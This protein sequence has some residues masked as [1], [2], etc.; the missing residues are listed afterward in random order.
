MFG[1]VVFLIVFALVVFYFPNLLSD[2]QNYI[3]ANPLQTPPEIVPEWYFLPYYAILRSIPSK[4]I[5]VCA[6]FGSLLT[7][8]PLPWLDTSRVRSSFFRPVY[9]WV[10]WLLVIDAIV[11]GVVGAHQ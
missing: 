10:F 11:L 4:L 5:R 9:K 8:V 1:R 6:M 3:P 2:P 7:V